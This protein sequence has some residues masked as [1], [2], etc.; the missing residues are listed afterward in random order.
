[1]AAAK[2]QEPATGDLIWCPT[3]IY[4]TNAGKQGDT[5]VATNTAAANAALAA[6]NAA[7][8]AADYAGLRVS[9]GAT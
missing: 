6:A 3:F 7:G 2:Y 4:G 1:M 8:T 5:A 9:S